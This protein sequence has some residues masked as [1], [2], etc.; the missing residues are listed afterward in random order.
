M[1]KLKNYVEFFVAY[2]RARLKLVRAFRSLPQRGRLPLSNA[3]AEKS[4]T[5]FPNLFLLHYSS[6]VMGVELIV[7]SKNYFKIPVSLS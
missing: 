6:S 1:R 2:P 5:G 7:K 4:A 3:Y